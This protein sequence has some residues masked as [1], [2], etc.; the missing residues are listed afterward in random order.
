MQEIQAL[1]Q[2]ATTSARWVAALLALA[3]IAMA[4]ARYL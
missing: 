3:V 4:V 2:R 1:R